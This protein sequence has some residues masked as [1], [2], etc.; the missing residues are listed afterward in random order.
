MFRIEEIT[1]GDLVLLYNSQRNK[2]ITRE[3]KL[4]FR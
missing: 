2:D 1:E 3:N 4:K